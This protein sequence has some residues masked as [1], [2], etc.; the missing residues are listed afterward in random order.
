[1]PLN[2]RVSPRNPSRLCKQRPASRQ[3]GLAETQRDRGLRGLGAG[4]PPPAG[5]APLPARSAPTPQAGGTR[6]SQRFPFRPA[7]RRSSR[8]GEPE[9]SPEEVARKEEERRAN[10]PPPP[11]PPPS[12]EP[13]RNPRPRSPRGDTDGR[14]SSHRGRRR[15][16][17]GE[18]QRGCAVPEGSAKPGEKRPSPAPGW[19]LAPYRPSPPPAGLRPAPHRTA[20]RSAPP[21]PPSRRPGRC[22]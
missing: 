10:T 14:G 13:V 11:P 21:R 3:A 6:G 18:T 12:P 20:P 19:G 15:G 1:M 2:R 16:D 22:V 7:R 4:T 17:G 9:A 5:G 8:N